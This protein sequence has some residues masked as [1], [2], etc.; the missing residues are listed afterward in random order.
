MDKKFKRLIVRKSEGILTITMSQPDRRNAMDG[1]MH[2]ELPEALALAARD[3][4]VRVIVLT[5]DNGVLRGSCRSAGDFD[6]L[7]ALNQAAAYTVKFGGHRKAAGLVVNKD[8][9]DSFRREINRY[10]RLH[11][12]PE[13]LRPAM[14]SAARSGPSSYVTDMP[15]S[16]A[17]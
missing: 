3:P 2:G 17:T 1:D 4:E 11:L 8:Q 14:R 16:F 15:T 10:A 13:P 5:G 12:P 9:L 6:M 7:A